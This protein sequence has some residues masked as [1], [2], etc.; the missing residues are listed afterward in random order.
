MIAAPYSADAKEADEGADMQR[1]VSARLADMDS[2]S[3]YALKQYQLLFKTNPDSRAV[4]DRLFNS[5]IKSGDMQS[6]V[7]AVRMQELRNQTDDAAPMLLFADAFRKKDWSTAQ[8]AVA[9]LQAKSNYAFIAPVLTSWIN[10]ATKKAPD[11]KPINPASE[12]ILNFYAS[13]QRV[14]MQ[15][16]AGNI[17][18][19]KNELQSFVGNDAD[20][21][22]DLIIRAAPIV[23]ANGESEFAKNILNNIVEQ[24]FIAALTS[25]PGS[26]TN[27]KLKPEHGLATIYVR[28]SNAL[29]EQKSYD[30]ALV[31]SRIAIWL[32]PSSDPAKLA[33][34]KSLR[35][36]NFGDAQNAI[37]S[38]ISVNSAYWPRAVADEV[39]ALASANQPKQA[40]LRATTAQ[41]QSPAS[42]N[43]ILL[44]AQ[45]HENAGDPK[46]AS[47]MYSQ[48]IDQ[49]AAQSIAPRQ[50][51][52]YLL[53]LATAQD[54]SGDWTSALKNLQDANA[55]DPDN[56]YILNYLGYA[57]LERNQQLDRAFGYV[58]RAHQLAPQSAA[59]TD[60]LGWGYYLTGQYELALPLLEKA[61]RSSGNDAAI[62]EHLGDVYWQLKRRIDARYAWKIAAQ[63]AQGKELTRLQNKIEYGL[64]KY[65]QT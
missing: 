40:L 59:I 11:L 50:K 48:I 36:N 22:R 30:Q 6:A 27:A 4:T 9:E 52:L 45:M 3:D 20:F 44:T 13:D 56:A 43:L 31:M 7:S 61:A 64:N 29:L 53:F 57:L 54:K 51:A 37:L 16:A 2:R 58:K 34:A 62:N 17:S 39:R 49:A 8:I 63:T 47:A 12:Q 46:S 14:Y 38:S 5:A 33:L 25:A 23:S 24:R 1:Y 15:L 10:V 21:A 28:F 32:D 65:V 55:I 41:K 60:S 35:E 26:K 19:A 18:G 42:A